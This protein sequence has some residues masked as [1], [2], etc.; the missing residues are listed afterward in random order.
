[1]VKLQAGELGKFID[2]AQMSTDDADMIVSIALSEAEL[3]ELVDS[4]GA[5]FGG[6]F[7]MP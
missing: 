4:M 2:K 3:T 6:M 5:M 7:G 1:M